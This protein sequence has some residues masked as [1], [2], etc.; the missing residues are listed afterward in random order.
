MHNTSWGIVSRNGKRFSMLPVFH[1]G[2]DVWPPRT[3]LVW[4]DIYSVWTVS[5]APK[6]VATW[7]LYGA[8]ESCRVKNEDS[9]AEETEKIRCHYINNIFKKNF[10]SLFSRTIYL[11]EIRIYWFWPNLQNWESS[12]KTFRIW[13]E[14]RGAR[15]P[16]LPRS[17]G[18]EGSGPQLAW[19]GVPGD[20]GATG[21][22]RG[23]GALPGGGRGQAAAEE[24]E[25]GL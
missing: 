23:K 19:G 14:A 16:V 3:F 6:A 8:A 24:R 1:W 21:G 4:T 12:G 25:R 2:R 5:Q 15:R 7:R 18:P 22:G 11:W 9:L 13:R 17:R 10:V 20:Q